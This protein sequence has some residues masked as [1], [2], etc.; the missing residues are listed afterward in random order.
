[1]CR[2]QRAILSYYDKILTGAQVTVATAHIN[3]ALLIPRI[4]FFYTLFIHCNFAVP[5]A[6]RLRIVQTTSGAY[7]APYSNGYRGS[8]PGVTW[9][10]GDVDH[11]RPSSADVM[12]E[13]SYASTPSISFHGK[14]NDN[15]LLVIT[16][17]SPA[18]CYPRASD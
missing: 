3:R 7:T 4:C 17:S 18:L 15:R 6:A 11:P 2:L 12:N 10:G 9:P 1:M 13:W 14:N 8:L 5:V 16:Y